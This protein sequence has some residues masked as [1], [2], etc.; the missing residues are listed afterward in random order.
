MVKKQLQVFH[1]GNDSI[2]PFPQI[3]IKNN[4]GNRNIWNYIFVISKWNRS[5]KHFKGFLDYVLLNLLDILNVLFNTIFNIDSI[6]QKDHDFSECQKHFTIPGA[7]SFLRCSISSCA[8][9]SVTVW[10]IIS[11]SILMLIV[12][13][14]N[15]CSILS[16]SPFICSGMVGTC[17]SSSSKIG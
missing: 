1:F 3:T 7:I 13:L 15:G 17:S 6:F 10:R 8:L 2:I 4:I 12:G 11:V 16:E 9:C 14:H 5:R